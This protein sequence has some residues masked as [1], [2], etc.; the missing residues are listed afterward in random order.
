MQYLEGYL[1]RTY[2]MY[3]ATSGKIDELLEKAR[4][5]ERT[6]ESDYDPDEYPQLKTLLDACQTIKCVCNGDGA[7]AAVATAGFVKN[8]ANDLK[9]YIRQYGQLILE[10]KITSTTYNQYEYTINDIGEDLGFDEYSKGFIAY[11]Y[12]A[13]WIYVQNT[14]GPFAGMLGFHRI[15]WNIVPQLVLRG[16]CWQLKNPG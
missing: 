2:G 10:T 5:I 13:N 14:L 9:Y 3:R 11:G 4:D 16:A 6:A 8:S 7:G 15:S 12:N 1:Y